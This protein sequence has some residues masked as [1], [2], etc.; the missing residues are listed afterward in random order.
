MKAQLQQQ[1]LSS[2]V[3]GSYSTFNRYRGGIYDDTKCGE[4]LDH[5]ITIVGWGNQPTEYWLIRNSWGTSW[6]EQG[7]MRMWITGGNGI[8]GVQKQP[9]YPIV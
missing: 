2:Y 5:A 7:Y 1:P 4:Y 9:E 3:H 6:G 8:C